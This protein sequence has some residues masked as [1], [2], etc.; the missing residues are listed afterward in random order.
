MHYHCARFS[1]KIPLTAVSLKRISKTVLW[2]TTKDLLTAV[3][4]ALHTAKKIRSSAGLS[5]P[6]NRGARGITD[7]TPKQ[8]VLVKYPWRYRHNYEVLYL[9]M[10]LQFPVLKQDLRS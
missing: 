2:D 10:L 5:S 3:I 7:V 9:M 8:Q 1:F 6:S 4:T